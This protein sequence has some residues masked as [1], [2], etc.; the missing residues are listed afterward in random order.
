MTR[1]DDDIIVDKVEKEFPTLMKE[2]KKIQEEQYRLFAKKHH[3]YGLKNIS[4]GEDI[5]TEE[6]RKIPTIGLVVRMRDKM[7]RLVNLVVGG[8]SNFVVEETVTDT[9]QDLSIYGV[10]AQILNNGKWIKD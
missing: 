5:T 6:G 3:D 7:E 4:F 1:K 9:F 2:F 8:K 10:I